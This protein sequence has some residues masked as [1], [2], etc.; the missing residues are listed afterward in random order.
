MNASGVCQKRRRQ[1]VLERL[2]EGI[3][4][5]LCDS[6]ELNLDFNLG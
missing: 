1:R 3:V 6:R 2:H 5:D 4:D